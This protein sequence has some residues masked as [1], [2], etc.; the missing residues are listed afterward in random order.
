MAEE[1][2]IRSLEAAPSRIY[3]ELCSGKTAK[4]DQKLVHLLTSAA[5]VFAAHGYEKASIRQVAQSAGV[6]LAGLYHY[7]RC[8]EELLFFMQYHTFGVLIERLEALLEKP[9]APE[10][11]LREMVSSHV[12]YLA[13]HLPELKLCTTELD[14]LQGE[15]YEKVLSRRQ[16]YF[17]LT[18]GILKKIGRHSSR[19]DPTLATFYLFGMLNWLVM[20]FD[21]SRNEPGKISK[22]LVELFLSGYERASGPG[23]AA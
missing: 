20:W 13:E 14:S 7:V 5:E 16:R 18:R 9:A 17:D 4:F 12:H 11:H 15:Y 19:V 10:A 23:G 8:K 2:H 1:R 22:S 6:S 21:P 3:G